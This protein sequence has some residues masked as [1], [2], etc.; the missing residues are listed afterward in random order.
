MEQERSAATLARRALTRE[1][2]ARILTGYVQGKTGQAL[3]EEF[4]VSTRVIAR[5]LLG[6]YD[7]WRNPDADRVL[8]KRQGRQNRFLTEQDVAE[9]R[10]MRV[11]GSSLSVIAA[12]F[13]LSDSTVS[14]IVRGIIH[15]PVEAR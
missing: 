15:G 8:A 4:H 7:R 14:R 6:D 10:R 11:D 5:V 1:E 2:G 9:I 12:H 13:L 3:A